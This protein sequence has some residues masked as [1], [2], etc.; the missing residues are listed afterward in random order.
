M[1]LKSINAL[2][3]E[4]QPDDVELVLFELER[5]GLF[6]NWQRAESEQEY[7]DLL[8]PELDLIL[9]DFHLPQFSALRALELMQARGLDIPFI[10]VTGSIS[11]EIAVECMKRGA[12]DYLLKDRLSRLGP[13]IF[14]A[15]RERRLHTEKERTEVA[16]RESEMK[17]KTLFSESLDVILLIHSQSGLVLDVNKSL[18][19]ALGYAPYQVVG[20]HYSILIP[21]VVRETAEDL[22]D[23]VRYHG[24]LFEYR[25]FLRADGTICPMDIT[26]TVIP[27]GSGTAVV[28]TLRDVSERLQAEEAQQTAE[29]L[30]TQLEHEK[31]LNELKSRFVSMVSHEYR[32]PL[33]T[34]MTSAELLL[35]YGSRMSDE[36][37][38]RHLA[39][40]QQSVKNMIALMNEVLA[41]E[42]LNVGQVQFEPREIDLTA[43]CAGIVEEINFN[44][45][46]KTPIAFMR[47][48]DPQPVHMDLSLLRQIVSNLLSN[49]V[50]YSPES[51]S[52]DFRLEWGAKQVVLTVSDH[53]IGIPEEDQ[54]RLFEP[55]HR[56]RNA[57]EISGTGLGLSI[58]KRAIELH[59]GS[60]G[61][62]SQVGIGTTF[63]V[64][65]PIRAADMPSA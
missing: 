9:A 16:L 26:A 18:Q 54:K 58:T 47:T 53:G 39:Q 45:Q 63:V 22:L 1:T 46:G 5:Q 43:F 42:K 11:E 40:I 48:G 57:G 20:K 7:L 32:S 52:V 37:S 35:R 64:M 36:Q 55:F 15:L 49:A 12:T 31:E 33:T 19:R 27:W 41:I 30:K 59:G 29:L 38:A 10:I 3:L 2:I 61:F 23:S 8:H 56:A 34:I 44:N 60:I 17:F 13:A 62:Q 50:K 28:A 51:A 6:L 14:Q 24:A 21:P 25:E 4:D 65:L